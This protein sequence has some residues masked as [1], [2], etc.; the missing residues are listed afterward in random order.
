[1]LTAFIDQN[2]HFAINILAAMVMSWCFWLFLDAWSVTKSVKEFLKFLGFLLLTFAFLI[3]SFSIETSVIAPFIDQELYN[4]LLLSTKFGGYLFILLSH[5]IDPILPKPFGKK[6]A[7]VGVMLPGLGISANL[8]GV[9]SLPI[10]SAGVGLTF[11]YKAT[12]GLEFHLRRVAFAFFG[13]SLFE[14]VSLRE[15]FENSRNVAV[16]SLVAPFNFLW[17]FEH[18]LLLL[19]SLILGKWVFSYLLKRLQTQL[20]IFFSIAILLIFI[21]STVSF[22]GFL[23]SNI[24]QESL[25]KLQTDVKVL[26]Y[27]I[28][29]K[30]QGLLSDSQVFAQNE[31]LTSAL[32]NDQKSEMAKLSSSFLLQKKLSFLVI[33]DINGQVVARGEEP[34]RIG[35]ALGSNSLVGRALEEKSSVSVSVRDGVL[36]PDVFVSAAYPIVDSENESSEGNVI[37]VVYAGQLIDNA[38]VDGLYAETGFSSSVY[39]GPKI[40]A[41]TYVA[42][43]G[44]TRRIGITESNLEIVNTVLGKGEPY[45][46]ETTFLNTPYVSAY[47][48]LK[49]VDG[50]PLGMLNVGNPQTTILA[51]AGRSMQG[52]YVVAGLL[53]LLAI[54]PSYL[55]A[56]YLAKQLK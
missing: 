22:T 25:E 7:A 43:D 19:V 48:P 15:L 41:T 31:N 52:S 4:T 6:A 54:L 33:V 5:L 24:R 49:D 35:E 2:I 12:L 53:W 13:L 16:F 28:E 36:S 29:L 32:L 3:H 37:G 10:L 51:T 44:V 55:I 34:E 8:M 45:A 47:L 50:T 26:N 38:F 17:W 18:V 1:M 39:G 42:E 40:S 21:I 23:L 46:G 56:G 27:A 20:Y 14:L 30:K 11:L 9:L